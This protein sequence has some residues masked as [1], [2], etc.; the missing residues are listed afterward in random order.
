MALFRTEVLVGRQL[1]DLFLDISVMKS[2]FPS[3]RRAAVCAG[4]GGSCSAWLT[5]MD[6]VLRYTVPV[7][8]NF[9]HLS[10]H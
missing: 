6:L 10:C 9:Y 4:A 5:V 2:E 8:A 3:S 1:L 7:E